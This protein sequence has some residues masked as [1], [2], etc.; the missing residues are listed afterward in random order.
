MKLK[1]LSALG[2]NS[3]P[4]PFASGGGPAT[5][6]QIYDIAIQ[7]TWILKVIHP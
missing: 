3:R 5:S 6:Q 2:L 7:I 4:V 1:T